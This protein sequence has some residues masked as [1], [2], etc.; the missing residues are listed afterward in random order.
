MIH[1]LDQIDNFTS[2]KWQSTKHQPR[3]AMNYAAWTHTKAT[4]ELEGA[5]KWQEAKLSLG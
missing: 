1:K 2:H 5:E 3:F 4:A